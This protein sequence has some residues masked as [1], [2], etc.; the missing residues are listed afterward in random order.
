VILARG[1]DFGALGFA[2]GYYADPRTFGVALTV[3]Y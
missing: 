2:G 3:K 1:I